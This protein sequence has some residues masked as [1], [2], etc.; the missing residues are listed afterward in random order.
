MEYILS[1][2]KALAM[3]LNSLQR[4]LKDRSKST[5]NLLLGVLRIH[6]FSVKGA[7]GLLESTEDTK[8]QVK[9]Y[10]Q[11]AFGDIQYIFS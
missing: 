8:R 7:N 9:K 2:S 10:I 1:V 5:F 11:L 6:F 3:I 4:T